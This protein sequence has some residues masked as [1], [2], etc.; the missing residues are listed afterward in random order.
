[1]QVS[2]LT[3]EK[4][5]ITFIDEKSGRIAITLLQSKDQALGAFQAYEARAEQEA[6]TQIRTLRTDDGGEYCGHCFQAY[7]LA[8]GIVHAVSLPYTPTQNGLAERANRTLMEGT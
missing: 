8:C 5:F 4:Y 7:I 6:G 2:T 1:M 3:G